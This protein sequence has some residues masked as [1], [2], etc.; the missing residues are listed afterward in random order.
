M[1]HGFYVWSAYGVVLLVMGG[2]V[3]ALM[4]KRKSLRP[5][6]AENPEVRQ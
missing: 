4:R 3:L 1:S 5:P 2:E 6:K